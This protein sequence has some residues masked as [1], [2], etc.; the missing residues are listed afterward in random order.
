MSTTTDEPLTWTLTP[1]EFAA[2]IERAQRINTRAT[3]RGFTGR[4][5]VTGTEREITEQDEAGLTRT[6]RVVDVEIS[7][8]APCYNGWQFLA[9]VDSIETESGTEFVLRTAPG[10]AESHVDRSTLVPGHCSHCTTVRRNRKYTYLVR[11][12][13]T[14]A[15]AQ[16]GSTCIKDF[17]GWEGKPIFISVKDLEEELDE[18]IGGLGA[19]A[20]EYSTATIVALAWAISR[21]YGWVPAAAEWGSRASTKSLVRDYLDGRSKA[22]AELRREIAPEIP[23]AEEKAQAIIPALLEGLEGDG[24]YVTNL[25][26]L[27][28]APFVEGKHLGIVTSAVSAYERML[29]ATTNKAAK[30]EEQIQSRY[31]GTVGEKLE[32]SGTVTRLVPMESNFGYYPT[33]NMLVIIQSGTT[34]AKMATA[35]AWAFDVEQGDQVVVVGTVK[36]H[37]EYRDVQQTVLTRP[38][39][40][41]HTATEGSTR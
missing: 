1:A 22:S 13:E 35:A 34:V 8:E 16:V 36:A 37:E 12:V 18:F 33:T 39:L 24:D 30:T 26:V 40:T 7:G 32:V 2:T 3:K 38:K 41:A 28:R 21:L 25:R 15:T 19:S 14:G 29:A 27:L 20:P 31:A 4:I 9:A 23:A 11:D 10:V 5:S 17:T 6:R